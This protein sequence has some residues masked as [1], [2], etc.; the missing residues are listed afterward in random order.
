[1]IRFKASPSHGILV[2]L[3]SSSQLTNLFPI[4]RFQ[5]C[6][7]EAWKAFAAMQCELFFIVLSALASKLKVVL[8]KLLLIKRMNYDFHSEP[9][10]AQTLFSHLHFNHFKS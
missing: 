4:P 1:M 6:L 3:F 7:S 5:L 8:E 9:N 2:C 10:D